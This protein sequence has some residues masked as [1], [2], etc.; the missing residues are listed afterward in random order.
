[1]STQMN[2]LVPTDFSEPAEHAFEYAVALA[3]K[4][5]ARI[6]VVHAIGM[7]ELGVPELGVALASTMMDSL[8]RKGQAS[9]DELRDRWKDKAS[10]GE[11][12]LRTGD[13]RDVVLQLANELAIDLIVIGTHG[14][15]GIARAVLGSVAEMVVRS[16]PC[17]VLTVGVKT[18]LR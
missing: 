12:V 16:A 9:L 17:P 10:F 5:G 15:H 7:L 18:V 8:V 4:L 1:M 3:S 6:H 11:L 2:I 13:V 14:R